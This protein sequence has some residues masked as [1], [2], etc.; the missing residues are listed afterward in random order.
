MEER[1]KVPAQKRMNITVDHNQRSIYQALEE[2]RSRG[3]H[4][5]CTI[6]IKEGN[7]YLD[8]PLLLGP[9]DS[10]LS[11]KGV[12]KVCLSGGRKIENWYRKSNGWWA[13]PLPDV[14]NGKWD[15]RMLIVNGRFASRARFPEKGFLIHESEFDVRWLSTYEGGFERE[16]SYEELTTLVYKEGDIGPDFVPENAEL[17][18]F[19]MWDESLVGVKD[20]DRDK[21][22]IV[23]SN[24]SGW[25]PGAFAGDYNFERRYIIWNTAEGMLQPGQW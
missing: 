19:H 3:K 18:V 25:P 9:E 5:P 15:F 4:A 17:T 1:S 8:R 2:S 14:A 21:R 13:S 22:H 10:H 24:P 12:G 7:Y 16:P 6:N 11:I 23:F 20:V